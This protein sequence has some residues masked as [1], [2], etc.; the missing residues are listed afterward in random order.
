MR[1]S[2]HVM[3]SDDEPRQVRLER[4]KTEKHLERFL[5]YFY[6][7]RVCTVYATPLLMSPIFF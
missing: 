7:A 5:V 4:I 1:Q 3:R 6:R 2:S